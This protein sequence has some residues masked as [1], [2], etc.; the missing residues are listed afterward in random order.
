MYTE[1][2][3]VY[4]YVYHVHVH[5]HLNVNVHVYVHVYMILIQYFNR[6]TSLRHQWNS[7]QQDFSPW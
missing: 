5:V 2:T 4:V 6:T 7:H 1:H 3:L